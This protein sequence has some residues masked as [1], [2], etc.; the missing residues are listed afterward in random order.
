MYTLLKY[1]L[2]SREHKK[3]TQYNNLTEGSRCKLLGEL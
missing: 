1:E 2:V 3:L